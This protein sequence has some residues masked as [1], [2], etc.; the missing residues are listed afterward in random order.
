MT[1]PFMMMWLSGEISQR[2]EQ[3]LSEP[4]LIEHSSRG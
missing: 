4:Q 3:A 2:G 1:G